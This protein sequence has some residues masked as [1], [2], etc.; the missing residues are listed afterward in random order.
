MAYRVRACRSLEEW[1]RA[2]G[3]IGHYFGWVP[4][5]EQIERFARLLPPERMHAAFDGGTIVGG[6]G[7][8]TFEMTAPGAVV[9]CAGVTVVGVLPTHRRR[10]LLSRMMRAQLDDIHERGEPI[11]ALFA[12]EE[13]IYGRYG[14]GLASLRQEVKLTGDRADLRPGTPP[15]TGSVRLVDEKGAARVFPR[16]YD[17]VRRVTPG[18][19]AR[20]RDWWELR[21][22][23]AAP[24]RRGD[25][26]PLNFA[27]AEVDGRPAGYAFYRIAQKEEEA[28]WKRRLRVIEALGADAIGTR[29]IWR[30]L[31]EIDWIHEVR[32]WLLPVDHPLFHLVARPDSLNLRTETGLWVRLVDVG[33]ALS[34][35]R[36]A[37][38]GRVTFEVSDGFAPWNA[39]TWTLADGIA[40]RSRR[41]PD[42]RL[43]V[44]GLGA[45]YLGGFSLRQLASAGLVEEVV[46]GGLG[47]ADVLFAP[48]G[49]APWCPEIF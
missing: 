8:F 36:Y 11:A 18:F 49:P 13:T 35:R 5:E 21:R 23:S 10:G 41:R 20:S 14:Y 34:A 46:R 15:R 6:A 39:G 1:G 9:P 28:G 47:R 42:V 48:T 7:A 43:D 16:L 40:R 30:F 32:A 22:L 45:A 19:L 3:S 2:V 29:E 44:T 37:T 24:E 17:R 33:A 38:D 25:A 27:L 26:G 4:T 31:L 12:S